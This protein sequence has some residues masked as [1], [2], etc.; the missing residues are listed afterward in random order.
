[1]DKQS[2]G[3]ERWISERRNEVKRKT[4]DSN[5][6]V[7]KMAVQQMDQLEAA[8]KIWRQYQDAALGPAHGA[9]VEAQALH[10]RPFQLQTE[11]REV[12]SLRQAH[13]GE[14]T[15]AAHAHRP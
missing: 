12:G 7:R 6:Q 3:F 2:A 8:L 9:S 1:M 4:L 15:P 14:N 11:R 13:S 10:L 5:F